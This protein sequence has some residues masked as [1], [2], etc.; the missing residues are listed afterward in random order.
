MITP[1]T[2]IKDV[3]FAIVDLETTGFSTLRGDRITEVG[4][5]KIKDGIEKETFSSLVNPSIP[6]PKETVSI[7]GI[8]DEMVSCSPRFDDIIDKMLEILHDTV[9][10]FHNAA[11]DMN[12]ICNEMNELN[13]PQLDNPVLDT[14]RLARKYFDFPSNSLGTIAVYL[15]IG[16]EEVRHRAMGDVRITEKVFSYFLEELKERKGL[17]TLGDLIALM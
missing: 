11:F 9:L 16:Q 12:F 8:T 17:K 13:I 2:Y 7:T 15:D 10:V 5:M 6:I 1:D 3:P 4:I 14:L